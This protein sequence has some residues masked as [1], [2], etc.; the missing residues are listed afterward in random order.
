MANGTRYNAPYKQWTSE[1]ALELLRCWARDGF[2][3]KEIASKIGVT[4]ETFCRWLKE[5][6]EIEEAIS[7]SREIADYKVE[8]ALY[9]RCVG[10]KVKEVKTIVSGALDKQGNRQTRIE[11]VEKEVPPDT[12]ACLAWLNNRKPTQWKRNRDVFISPEEANMR[13][14]NIT[15]VK[16]DRKKSTSIKAEFDDEEA[17]WEAEWNAAEDEDWNEND[18]V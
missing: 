5:H 15:I 4:Q 17:E 12:T 10:F 18:E 14:V 13:N 7:F 8:A 11:T 9:K 2:T 6:P 1:E 16:G 3:Q